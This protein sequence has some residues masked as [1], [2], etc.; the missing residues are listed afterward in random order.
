M[1]EESI[2]ILLNIEINRNKT[3]VNINE[4]SYSYGFI[5]GLRCVLDE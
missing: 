2:K 4:I 5:A 1:D 3:L